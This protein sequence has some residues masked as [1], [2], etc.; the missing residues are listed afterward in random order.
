[1]AGRMRATSSWGTPARA[2]ARSAMIATAP[3]ATACGMKSWPSCLAPEMATK[4]KPARTSLESWVTPRTRASAVGDW[5]CSRVRSSPRT[6]SSRISSPSGRPSVIY[7]SGRGTAL[8]AASQ[9]A[10]AYPRAVVRAKGRPQRRR[11]HQ[12]VGPDVADLAPAEALLELGDAGRGHA[13][14]VVDLVSP[15]GRAADGLP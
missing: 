8:V 11:R 10:D 9:P 14:H 2:T 3:F 7:G 12:V 15:F 5:P 1:M 13:P 4:I 6:S